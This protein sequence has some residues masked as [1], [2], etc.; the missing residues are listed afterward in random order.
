[1]LGETPSKSD[2]TGWSDWTIDG[3]VARLPGRDGQMIKS[4]QRQIGL[5]TDLNQAYRTGPTGLERYS[6]RGP[7]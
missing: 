6:G 7:Q 3:P 1:M 5:R 4:Q 2:W